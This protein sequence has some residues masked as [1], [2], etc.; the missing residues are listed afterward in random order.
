MEKIYNCASCHEGFCVQ[1]VVEDSAEIPEIPF[2]VECPS[3]N[4]QNP[5]TWPQG[6][7]YFVTPVN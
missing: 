7:A 6:A 3:C 2:N 1:G 4:Q 5:V